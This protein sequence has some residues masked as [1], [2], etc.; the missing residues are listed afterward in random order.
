MFNATKMRAKNAARTLLATSCL[1]ILSACATPTNDDPVEPLNRAI[2]S[3]NETVDGY[4]LRPVAKGYTAVVP[5][6]GREHVGNVLHNLTM[7]LVFANSV[8]QGDAKNAFSA[9]WSFVLNSTFGIAGIFDFTEQNSNL[10][11]HDED[12]GQTLGV[13]GIDQ[14]AYIVLPFFGPSSTRD[15]L[16]FAVDIVSDPFNYTDETFTIS[17]SVT[18]VIHTRSTLLELM[19]DIYDT[20]LDPY[21]TI[22]SGYLQKRR[23]DVKNTKSEVI[24]EGF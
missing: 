23:A 5:A 14:G 10:R 4:L 15:T 21:A 16:G 9:F 7:P 6:Q 1:A 2:F 22:R 20:S 24:N 11:V 8:L 3:F 18:K 13:W 19:D 17:H 12:F